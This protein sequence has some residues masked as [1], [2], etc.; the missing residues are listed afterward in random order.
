[1]TRIAIFITRDKFIAAMPT[2]KPASGFY[3]LVHPPVPT[4]ELELTVQADAL[5]VPFGPQGVNKPE[6]LL[7][8][9]LRQVILDRKRSQQKKRRLLYGRIWETKLRQNR[10]RLRGW[11]TPACSETEQRVVHFDPPASIDE[12]SFDEC[13]LDSVRTWLQQM[14]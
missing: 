5:P 10:R 3:R 4:D 1:V 7:V 9:Q 2:R 13:W 8:K 11:Q 14:D 6:Q 12:L